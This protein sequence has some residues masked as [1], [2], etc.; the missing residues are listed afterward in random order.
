MDLPVSTQGSRA[1]HP[2]V[3][4]AVSVAYLLQCL[5]THFSILYAY[6]NK[7]GDYLAKNIVENKP[8]PKH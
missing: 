4:K 5:S 1:V 3:P 7:L 2:L 8:V 6:D